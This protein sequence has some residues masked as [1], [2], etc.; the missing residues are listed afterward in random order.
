MYK[1][2]IQK[3]TDLFQTGKGM[4]VFHFIRRLTEYEKVIC[5]EM[6][7]TVK[8]HKETGIQAAVQGE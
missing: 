2:L 6:Y 5:D 4:R 7:N 8:L 3:E 1:C